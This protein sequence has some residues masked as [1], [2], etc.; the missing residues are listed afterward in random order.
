M[1]RDTTD[2]LPGMV[3]HVVLDD[4]TYLM[5]DAALKPH[6]QEA[7]NQNITFAIQNFKKK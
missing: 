1:E 4:V 5:Y 6:M 7:W 2:G 3:V